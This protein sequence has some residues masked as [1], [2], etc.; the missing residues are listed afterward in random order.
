MIKSLLSVIILVAIVGG[1]IKF[2]STEDSWSLVVN[3]EDALYS[4][5]NGAIRLYELGVSA[6]ESFE[7]TEEDLEFKPLTTK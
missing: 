7:N 2:E 6:V 4:V 5:Q 1:A 3:K